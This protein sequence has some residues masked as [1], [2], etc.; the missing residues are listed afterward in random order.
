MEQG[1]GY[2]NYIKDAMG[3]WRNWTAQVPSK[4]PVGGSS[5]STPAI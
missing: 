5:P 2:S 1:I 4:H 3:V